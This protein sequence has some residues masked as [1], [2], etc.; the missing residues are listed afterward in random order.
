MEI[1]QN[2]YRELLAK[3]IPYLKEESYPV[4]LDEIIVFWMRHMDLIQIFLKTYVVHKECYIFTAA[5][6]MDI[7]EKENYPFMLLGDLHIMDDPL[8][9]YC[10]MCSKLQKDEEVSNEFWQQ[11]I[12]TVNDNIKIIEECLGDIYVI[13]IRLLNQLSDNKEIIR[14]G[15][16][17]FVNLFKD[18]SSMKEYFTVCKTFDDII[19]HL[20]D[21][22]EN[23]ILFNNNDNRELPI[24]DRLSNIVPNVPH[25]IKGNYPENIIFFQMVFGSIQQA[26]DVL[27]TCIEYKTVP[28]IRYKAALNYFLFLV[29]SL[30]DT[31]K[32]DEL[33][34]KTC[35]TNLIYQI[36]D[37]ERL[38]RKGFK[39]FISTIKEIDF[40]KKIFMELEE[41]VALEDRLNISIILPVIEGILNELYE[42]I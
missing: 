9:K 20:G 30:R 33:K 7:A 28:L 29:D 10:E 22:A 12:L 26:V 6:Y 18:I 36:C 23:I 40:G 5:T 13:P 11:I 35:I 14:I 3:L 24:R 34:Y 32:M 25:L 39:H 41:K 15:E 19:E 4:A 37:K 21:G 38:S 17:V 1:L 16:Q 8:G 2:E 42:T 31:E 27:L